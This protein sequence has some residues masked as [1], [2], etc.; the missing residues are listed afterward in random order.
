MKLSFQT[1]E[2]EKKKDEIK[3]SILYCSKKKKTNCPFYSEFQSNKNEEYFL[4]GFFNQHNHKLETFDCSKLLKTKKINKIQS[5]KS[6]GTDAQVIT[7]IINTDF[8]TN[9]HYSTIYYQMKKI[10]DKEFGEITQ[11]ADT[12]ICLRKMLLIG[13]GFSRLKK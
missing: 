10:T 13:E 4:K 3:I 8:K 12:L 1:Q 7:K 11:D 6:T 5:L 9:F 2:K